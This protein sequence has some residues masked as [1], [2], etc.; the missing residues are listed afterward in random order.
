MYAISVVENKEL[1]TTHRGW[2]QEPERWQ[3]DSYH[4]PVNFKAGW[5]F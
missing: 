1:S 5:W 3:Y 2:L 4:K